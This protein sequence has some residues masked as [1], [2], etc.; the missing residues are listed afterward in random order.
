MIRKILLIDSNLGYNIYPAKVLSQFYDVDYF[1]FT[2]ESLPKE[3]TYLLGVNEVNRIYNLDLVYSDYDII[4]IMDSTIPLKN[5]NTLGKKYW[6]ISQIYNVR[7]YE[8]NRIELKEK[9]RQIIENSEINGIKIPNYYLFENLKE[10]NKFLSKN[11]DKKFVVKPNINIRFESFNIFYNYS[12]NIRK[13]LE[14]LEWILKSLDEKIYIEEYI[15]GLDEIGGETILFNGK[16]CNIYLIGKEGNIK[17]GY[18]T[19]SD[20][21]IN[22]FF[23]LFSEYLFPVDFNGIVSVEGGLD[24]D[25]N[26]WIFE[27]NIRPSQPT[28]L[29]WFYYFPDIF[30]IDRY[31]AELLN[32]HKTIKYNFRQVYNEKINFYDTLTLDRAK[33]YDKLPPKLLP[34][35][36][37]KD[38]KGRYIFLGKRIGLEKI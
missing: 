29:L 17:S 25:D 12:S 16:S 20:V 33:I 18:I 4:M 5:I 28:S 26:Y 9:L 24:K 8:L 31:R 6:G 30:N 37:F 7:K 13:K 14:K 1:I 22:H 15:S 11:K 3:E 27:M 32:K 2:G 36:Y 38:E 19:L 10:L 35:T 23:S 34:Q 21:L